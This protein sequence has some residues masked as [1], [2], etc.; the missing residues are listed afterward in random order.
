MGDAVE[1]LVPMLD[2]QLIEQRVHMTITGQSRV[3]I[4]DVD[5]DGQLSTD[6]ADV[7]ARPGLRVVLPED[8]L[9]GVEHL[10]IA[11]MR[12][13]TK[14]LG[15]TISARKRHHRAEQ[16]RILDSEPHGAKAS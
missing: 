15:P 8:L 9:I 16:V 2:F 6:L 12:I 7:A 13:D 1:F 10:R 4:P 11:G 3:L 14:L 5:L